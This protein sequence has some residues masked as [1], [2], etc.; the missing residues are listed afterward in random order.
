MPYKFTVPTGWKWV[1]WG[2]YYYYNDE[3]HVATPPKPLDVTVDDK[4]LSFEL[5]THLNSKGTDAT[6]LVFS[7]LV[8][9]VAGTKPDVYKDGQAVVGK[10]GQ[11]LLPVKT[12]LWG[13][14]Q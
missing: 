10:D 9:P 7:V 2:S 3:T 8:E 6:R 5:D 11:A 14:T 13:I 4:V 12:A 1:E